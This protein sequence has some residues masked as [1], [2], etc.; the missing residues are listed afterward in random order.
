[1]L[2]RR[3]AVQADA[4]DADHG[5]LDRQDIALLAVG[6]VAR[7]AHGPRRPRCRGR[8][9]RRS[10]AASTAVPSYHRQ[11]VFLLVISFSSASQWQNR[12]ACPNS[13]AARPI[14]R[15]ARAP[16]ARGTAAARAHVERV[17]PRIEV[18]H[19]GDPVLSGAWSSVASCARSAVSL[20][21]RAPALREGDEE[22][23]VLLPH[24]FRVGGPA[25]RASRGRRRR[26][27]RGRPRS[28]MFSVS[29]SLPLTARSGKR[30]VRGELIAP[31]ARPRPGSARCPR[32]STSGASRPSAS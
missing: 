5:E 29:V 16:R 25:R 2:E 8:S 26:R 9:R 20:I 30:L 22:L 21:L 1:M 17:V 32:R 18:A 12:R 13:R 19:C 4:G 3:A 11:I 23:P 31:A 14:T 10:C 15:P 7:R 6:I 27:R 24:V 28:A